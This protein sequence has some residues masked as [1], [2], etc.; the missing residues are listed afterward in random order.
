MIHNPVT[1]TR[2]VDP[3]L[4]SLSTHT[5]HQYEQATG[6]PYIFL[7]HYFS[8]QFPLS[9]PTV[10][11]ITLSQSH[12]VNRFPI[13]P[14]FLSLTRILHHDSTEH[15]TL[16]IHDIPHTFSAV[17]TIL[18]FTPRVRLSAAIYHQQCLTHKLRI[19]LCG[20]PPQASNPSI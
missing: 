9:D 14:V 5:R 11:Y 19:T 3:L 16:P 18:S 17:D 20:Q 12:G 8:V 15:N 7:L 6:A 10:T 1:V 2:R 4:L 13:A